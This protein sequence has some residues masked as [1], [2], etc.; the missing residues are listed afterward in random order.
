[1]VGSVG[2]Q[3]WLEKLDEQRMDQRKEEKTPQ[4]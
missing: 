4:F 1:M 3:T 2:T